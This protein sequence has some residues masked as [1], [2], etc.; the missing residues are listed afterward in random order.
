MSKCGIF[1]NFTKVCEVDDGKG[2]CRHRND[3]DVLPILKLLA[4][5]KEVGPP[6]AILPIIPASDKEQVT[7][8]IRR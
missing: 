1:N 7:F 8:W 5:A 6:V 4:E 2:M 3:C